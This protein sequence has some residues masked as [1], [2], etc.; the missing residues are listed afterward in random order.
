MSLDRR[1]LD[2]EFQALGRLICPEPRQ[3]A[4]E[5]IDK[6]RRPR[7][8]KSLLP[9]AQHL[10]RLS[11]ALAVGA[12][13]MM[14]GGPL[15]L[16][17]AGT[18][19]SGRNT[20]AHQLLSPLL[21][22]AD[23]GNHDGQGG[24]Q[25]AAPYLTARAGAPGAGPGATGAA[26]H[27][28]AAP[29]NPAAPGQSGAPGA[30]GPGAPTPSPSPTTASTY[31]NTTDVAI[32][33]GTDRKA[34]SGSQPVGFAMLA[35]NTGRTA[36]FVATD[37]CHATFQVSDA[38][39]RLV[40]GSQQE[41]VTPCSAVLITSSVTLDP[42]QTVTVSYS[43]NRTQC[44]DPGQLTCTQTSPVPAGSYSVTGNLSG[45]N[46]ANNGVATSPPVRFSLL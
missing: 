46:G 18:G 16:S 2:R 39:G 41:P 14:L 24:D 20:V 29:A 25:A 12:A 35:R 1:E 23:A 27:P 19:Q 22:E 5:V 42:G 21:R 4:R 33:A 3:V 28:A 30:P 8:L 31:C 38:G 11:P 32:T 37:E 36:C 7:R 6:A 17:L 13:V 45:L 34:Y 40:F 44:T 10:R 15:A 26:G 43:W 9:Q